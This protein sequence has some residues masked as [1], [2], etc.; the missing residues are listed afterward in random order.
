[1]QEGNL[2]A[3]GGSIKK[4]YDLGEGTGFIGWE[5]GEGGG[6]LKPAL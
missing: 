5:E 3:A 1:M 6:C 4:Q 2:A